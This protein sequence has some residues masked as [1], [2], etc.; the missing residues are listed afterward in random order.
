MNEVEQ[1]IDNFKSDY[2][3][4]IELVFTEGN[5]YYFAVIL[6]ERFNGTIYYLPIDNHFVC[7]IDADFYDITGKL[8]LSE[9]PV[10]WEDLEQ[11]DAAHYKRIVRDC[12]MKLQQ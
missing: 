3:E 7:K 2:K 5:C 6:R 9:S 12:I 10:N 8:T 1:F 4:E 11:Q